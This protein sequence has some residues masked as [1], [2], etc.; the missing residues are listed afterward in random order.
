L[1]S[2]R[3][4][5][6]SQLQPADARVSRRRAKVGSYVFK[7][8]ALVLPVKEIGGRYRRFGPVF[9]WVCF[10]EFN[11]TLPRRIRKRLYEHGI[12]YTEDRRVCTYSKGQSHDRYRC[13]TRAL[14]QHSGTVAQVPHY[15]FHRPSNIGF[16][17]SASSNTVSIEVV[18]N[19]DHSHRSA[20][21]GST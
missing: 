16:L 21:I 7:G 4:T 9:G 12:Y 18:T 3:L 11:E 14:D 19:R 6:A 15:L 2:L 13:E 17:R 10:P 1:H 20:T 5:I 8:L